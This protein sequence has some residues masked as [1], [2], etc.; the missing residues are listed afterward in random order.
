LGG[1]RLRCTTRWRAPSLDRRLAE[2][3][4]PIESDQLALRVGQLCA[5]ATRARLAGAL[6]LTVRLA[7]EYPPAWTSTRLR[8][9]DIRNSGELLLALADRVADDEP[10]GVRGLA[11][12]ARLLNGPRSPLYSDRAERPLSVAAFEALVELDRRRRTGYTAA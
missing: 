11:M 1:I 5:P 3:A 6:R 9:A 8:T 10:V 12:T 7:S 2:G 4:D